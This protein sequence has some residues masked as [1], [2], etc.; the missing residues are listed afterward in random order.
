MSPLPTDQA[1]SR[2][3]SSISKNSSGPFCTRAHLS[4]ALPSW[5]SIRHPC[6]L[7]QAAAEA[8]QFLLV[9]HSAIPS[10][11]IL[12]PDIPCRAD[13][14]ELRPLR[15]SETAHLLIKAVIRIII[16]AL[17]YLSQRGQPPFLFH[18]KIVIHIRINRDA[19]PGVRRTCVPAGTTGSLPSICMDVIPL[20]PDL[21]PVSN[22]RRGSEHCRRPC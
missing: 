11:V 19:L 3:L 4:Q 10:P 8:Q 9:S 21:L 13:G 15:F 17:A 22:Y 16:V 5:Y 2:H 20:C 6:R 7:F 12:L 18:F 1:G 14:R